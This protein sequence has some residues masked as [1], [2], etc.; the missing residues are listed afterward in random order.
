M[1]RGIWVRLAAPPRVLYGAASMAL[2]RMCGFDHWNTGTDLVNNM[3]TSHAGGT[4]TS[5]AARNGTNGL[6]LTTSGAGAGVA[7]GMLAARQSSVSIN[8]TGTLTAGVAFRVANLPTSTNKMHLLQFIDTAWAQVGVSVFLNSSGELRFTN[9]GSTSQTADT[10][11]TG[12]TIAANTWYYLE[13]RAKWT[14][15]TAAGDVQIHL[16]GSL[17]N[18]MAT[19]KN[20][21]NG[22]SGYL[23]IA[24]G[25]SSGQATGR[26]SSNLDF[27][28]V[29]I[30][31]ATGSFNTTFLGDCVVEV[32]YPSAA[33][34]SS[35]WTPHASTNVSQVQE[36]IEDGD[37]SYV[38]TAS[39]NNRDSYVMDDLGETPLSVYAVQ[40]T[41]I[42]RTD[43][44]EASRTV[45][46]SV[47]T[48]GTYQ[49]GIT[50]VAQAGSYNFVR[51]VF[52]HDDASAAWTPTSVNAMEAGVK[53]VN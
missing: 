16:N 44:S 24:L 23:Y 51:G 48:N 11:Y 53:L 7:C 26:N 52:D 47:R 27:D 37:T 14:A 20:T 38:S 32:L 36:S 15:S 40:V 34:A 45:A 42:T 18:E 4:V 29:Y 5:S 35:Q 21:K 50:S 9:V 17:V 28:D 39:V 22:A 43:A 8:T 25:D 19:G 2:I 3:S 12:P 49:D 30:L 6:R 1:G 13:L 31:D 46:C 33:G 10:G 41:A